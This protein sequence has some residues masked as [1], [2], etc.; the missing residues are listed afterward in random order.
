MKLPNLSTIEGIKLA[1]LA[2]EF[3]MIAVAGLTV[4]MMLKYNNIAIKV[5][6]ILFAGAILWV[7]ITLLFSIFEVGGK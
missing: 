4:G 1:L 2:L 6:A 5:I 7:N 3:P